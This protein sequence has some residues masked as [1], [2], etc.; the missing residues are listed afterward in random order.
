MVKVFLTATEVQA[1]DAVL[2]IEKMEELHEKYK[3]ILLQES[4]STTVHEI[5]DF[6]FE[7]PFITIPEVKERINSHYSKAKYNIEILLRL[8]IIEEIKRDKG[9]RLFVAR[10]IIEVLEL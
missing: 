2:R 3:N 6:L 4:Q 7:N 10:E 8:G 5:L 1:N 9:E